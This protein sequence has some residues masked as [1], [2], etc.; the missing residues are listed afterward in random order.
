MT[1]NEVTTQTG[2]LPTNFSDDPYLDYG[3]E[4][5]TAG[6]SFL[7]FDRTGAGFTYGIDNTPLPLGT[8]LAA[9]MA[10][11]RVGWLKW[12]DG[13]PE[14]VLNLVSERRKISKDDLGPDDPD[15]PWKEAA[16]LELVDNT[17]QQYIF[18][19]SSFGG[20]KGVKKLCYDFARER[21]SRPGQIP[22]V[23]LGQHWYPH[24]KYNKVWEPDFTIVDW[25]DETTLAPAGKPE[26]EAPD[27]LTPT[28]E[29]PF[30]DEEK[31]TETKASKP[32]PVLKAKGPRF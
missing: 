2:G 32:V 15:A 18:S 7:K 11:V 20:T 4:A 21:R 31:P 17:R 1:I 5:A 26:E 22:V 24:P 28:E 14:K 6:A 8:R 29:V 19:T 13:K 10:G 25:V 16:E 12:L 27:H 30:V 9:N 3:I 23:E